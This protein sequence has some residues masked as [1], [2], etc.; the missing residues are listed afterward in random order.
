MRP[1]LF[2]FPL[3]LAACDP[4]ELRSDINERAAR[5]VIVNVL[6]GQYP[7]PQAEAA[8]TCVIQNATQ[9]ELESLARDVGT[10][11]GT[12]TVATIRAVDDRP[13]TRTC[14]QSQGLL[15]IAV[16]S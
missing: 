1:A 12:T 7:R 15:P 9:A 6:A 16:A 14:L 10:R 11:A 4:A 2:L 13:A 8:T 5:S 3:A